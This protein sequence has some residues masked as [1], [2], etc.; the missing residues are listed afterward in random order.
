MSTTSRGPSRRTLVKG[1]AWSVPVVAVAG[2]APALAASPVIIY[3]SGE[4]CKVASTDDFRF[5]FDTTL[6]VGTQVTVTSWTWTANDGS[7]AF[8][9]F[10]P[11][12]TTVTDS[13]QLVFVFLANGTTN[14]NLVIC[15]NWTGPDVEDGDTCIDTQSN[16]F[17]NCDGNPS[18]Y[19]RRSSGPESSHYDPPI[20]AW[21]SATPGKAT[22]EAADVKV[23]EAPAAESVEA[24]APVESTEAPAPAPA[25][26]DD[27]S[28]TSAP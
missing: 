12:T 9:S 16:N 3:N 24:P 28:A 7:T 13:G 5:V 8:F 4:S 27:A 14:G 20:I 11:V 6:P 2:A 19:P 25:P 18:T 26:G 17:A 10:G 23:D 22:T 21:P 1:A 15:F